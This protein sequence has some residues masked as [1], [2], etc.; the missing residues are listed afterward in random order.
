M[1]LQ[2]PNEKLIETQKTF[3]RTDEIRVE[4]GDDAFNGESE[5][6]DNEEY[7][8]LDEEN[9]EEQEIDYEYA[10]ERYDSW[11]NESGEMVII[12]PEDFEFLF[13]SR[14]CPNCHRFHDNS[15]DEDEEGIMQKTL[16]F[17]DTLNELS[18][19]DE[20]PYA[21]N[22]SQFDEEDFEN[23][24]IGIR[25][26]KEYYVF[27]LGVFNQFIKIFKPTIHYNTSLE[28]MVG[29][30]IMTLF[31]ECYEG[32]GHLV[33]D[34]PLEFFYNMLDLKY[35]HPAFNYSE[36]E[37]LD[38]AK[39]VY[40]NKERKIQEKTR[41]TNNPK[42]K[43]EEEEIQNIFNDL[44]YMK[45]RDPF[46]IKIKEDFFDIF[47]EFSVLDDGKD[48]S[49]F[50]SDT[51]LTEIY[52]DKTK[53]DIG[54]INKGFTQDDLYKKYIEYDNDSKDNIIYKTSFNN[55]CND[56]L[57]KI[58]FLRANLGYSCVYLLKEK[59]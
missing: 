32:E 39:K 47:E 9:S 31:Y 36:E 23:V 57:R 51:F 37:L 42:I 41:D 48:V 1:G 56:K 2:K 20:L 46:T 58:K 25:R 16:D 59:I 54:T 5:E 24:P 35:D 43:T 30:K 33:I 53:K 14:W 22:L 6:E 21:N 29:C 49:S 38:Y 13:D 45:A 3:Y 28:F 8:D 34:N 55:T 17:E 18:R 44:L 52:N 40:K 7:D 11:I 27:T 50:P 4:D 15:E 26:T 19:L 12:I 10:L